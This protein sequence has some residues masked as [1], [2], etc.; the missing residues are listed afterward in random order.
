MSFAELQRDVDG[1]ITQ[2]EEGYWQPLSMLARVSEEVGE[3]AREI[4]HLYGEKPKKADEESA[5]L[6]MEIADVMFVMIALANS[7]GIDLDEAFEQMMNKY[8]DRDSDRWTRRN[9]GAQRTE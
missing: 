7:L 3:L 8:R 1:W 6:A 5:D 2:F 9:S 4:N